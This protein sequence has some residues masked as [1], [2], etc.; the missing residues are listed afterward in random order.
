[1]STTCPRL[2]RAKRAS[3]T[4][5][6]RARPIP[7]STPRSPSSAFGRHSALPDT[8]PVSMDH[9]PKIDPTPM[10]VV[11][12]H[13]IHAS[14]MA[15]NRAYWALPGI[16]GTVWEHY[17]LVASQWPTIPA[18]AKPAKR[19]RL[20]PR[21]AARGGRAARE[22]SVRGRSTGKPGQ[23][24]DRDLFPGP[25]VKLHVLPPEPVQRARPRLRRHAGQLSIDAAAEGR[26][27]QSSM[28]LD[29]F[30]R[31]A[32]VKVGRRRRSRP[33]CATSEHNGQITSSMVPAHCTNRDAEQWK[34][35]FHSR[36][37]Y[38]GSGQG[39]STIFPPRPPASIRSWTSR[40]AASG[41]R[42]TTTGCMA[43]SRN[44]SNKAAMSALNS[45]GA[46][47]GDR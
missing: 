25:A 18:S 42:S 47:R 6:T 23:H 2:A 37:S 8:L 32:A 28:S 21:T 46:S 3:P 41:R 24:D 34:A 22:L 16:K 39:S 17:M 26:A 31:A 33:V 1:M 20:F 11:R 4:P 29:L 12:R 7:I 30:R 43:P 36:R 14:T 9:P 10:Q 40:A 5:G 13:P 44:R 19:R 38:S 27:R 15:M 45:W 35:R